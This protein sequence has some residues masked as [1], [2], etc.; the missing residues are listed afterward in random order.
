MKFTSAFCAGANTVWAIVNLMEG[1]PWWVAFSLVG[2][3]L[4]VNGYRSTPN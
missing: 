1:R 2:V 4:G 3:W